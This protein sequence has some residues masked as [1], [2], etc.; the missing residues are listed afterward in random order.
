MS[1]T[2]LASLLM[3]A[4][5]GAYVVFSTTISE[6][7]T[8]ALLMGS[9]ILVN[10]LYFYFFAA[11]AELDSTAKRELRTAPSFEWWLR[12][13]NQTLLFSLW[14]SLQWGFGVFGAALLM[15]YGGYIAWDLVVW[16]HVKDHMLF[17]YD[18]AGLILAAAFLWIEAEVAAMPKGAE[19]KERLY[20]LAGGITFLYLMLAVMGVKYGIVK[21]GFNPFSKQHMERGARR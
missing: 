18:T 8:I 4:I 16:K 5:T 21:L 3:F 10:A 15:L 20:F 1:A 2:F 11:H 7:S 6:D 17:F 9:T 12:V 19:F 13:L 14:F